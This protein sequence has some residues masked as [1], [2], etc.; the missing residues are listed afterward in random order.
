MQVLI[1]QKLFNFI[2]VVECNLR[3]NQNKTF[4]HHKIHQKNYLK[5]REKLASS[6]EV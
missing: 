2:I 4:N 5:C 1:L 6:M 3:Y